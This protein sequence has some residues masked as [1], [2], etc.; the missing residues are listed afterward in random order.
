MTAPARA[1]DP[2]ADRVEAARRATVDWLAAMQAP[3]LP[4]GVSRISAAHDV[5]AWP[6]VLLPGTYN[7][8]MCATLIGAPA[9]DPAPLVAWLESHRLADGRFR[10]PGLDEGAV[11]KKPDPAET[12][13]YIDFHVTNYALG[14]VEALAPGRPANLAFARRFLD[15]TALGDWLSRRDLRDPWQEGNNLVNLG[16]FLRALRAQGATE[17]NRALALWFDWHERLQEPS[18]GFWGVGQ[19]DDARQLLHAFAGSMHDYHLYYAERRPI[20]FHER[21]V[22]YALTLPPRIDSACIDVDAVDLLVHGLMLRGHRRAETLDWLRALLPELLGWQ[23]AD[24][25]FCDVREG[26]RRQDGWIGGYAEPQGLSNTFATYFRWIAIAMIAEVFWPGRW[27]WAFR[28]DV[29]IG[30]RAPAR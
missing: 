13:G 20:P 29:G 23:E 14:A 16:G 12:W 15:P 19:H 1:R 4:A 6:G 18:T 22:D 24:G 26:V 2:L 8:V 30:Y 17:A 27:P 11:F 3:G 25:G 5:Q 7:A 21:A 28:R 10:V 9:P